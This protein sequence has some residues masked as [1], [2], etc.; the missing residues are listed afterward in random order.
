MQT[1]EKDLL[2]I[3][4]LNQ[5]GVPFLSHPRMI[6]NSVTLE[7]TDLLQHLTQS[8][9]PRL[10][11]GITAFFLTHPEQAQVIFKVLPLL[12]KHSQELLKY[13]Y[14]AAVYLQELWKSQLKERV[15]L[16]NYFSREL[17]LPEVTVLHGRLG[18]AFLEDALQRWAHEPYNYQSAFESL[19][20]LV[21]Y[22]GAVCETTCHF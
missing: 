3:A 10:K 4:T 11:L 21:Q 18:L 5:W 13:Y 19:V 16:S 1:E 7:L 2:A 22:Q 17:Q 20:R 15:P 14:T 8:H 9:S 12:G 6:E